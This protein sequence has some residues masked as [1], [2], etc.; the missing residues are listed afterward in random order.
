M[1]LASIFL[2]L[3]V[4]A[5]V[6]V[7]VASPFVTRT[8][9]ARV[10]DPVFS[11]LLT[12]RDRILREIQELDFDYKLGKI[13]AEV[14]PSQRA[15]LVQSGAGILRQLGTHQDETKKPVTKGTPAPQTSS[16]DEI[17]DLIANR[18]SI[19][20]EKSGGFCPKCGKT[21]LLSDHFCPKCGYSL[22]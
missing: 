19:R 18:R 10:D 5:M 7:F 2:L 1:E 9:K 6:A 4:L 13:P 3:A 11:T 20:K 12:E 17:E 22:R 8:R 16:D 14:Y 21:V 15:L